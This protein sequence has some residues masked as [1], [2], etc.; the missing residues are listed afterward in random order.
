M[1][2][3]VISIPFPWLLTINWLCM[4]SRWCLVDVFWPDEMWIHHWLGKCGLIWCY[5]TL[6]SYMIED[7]L[8]WIFS[9]A[10]HWPLQQK[11]V[12]IGKESEMD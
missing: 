1:N 5:L 6:T 10:F 9:K 7:M 12:Q 2:P 8:E 11:Y 3:V 4:Q